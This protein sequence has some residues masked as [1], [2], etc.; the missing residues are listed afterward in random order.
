MCDRQVKKETLKSMLLFQFEVK[1][2]DKDPACFL[3]TCHNFY[4]TTDADFFLVQTD[5]CSVYCLFWLCLKIQRDEVLLL[6]FQ[7]RSGVF[8]QGVIIPQL[9]L[10]GALPLGLIQGLFSVLQDSRPLLLCA[11]HFLLK[12][13]FFVL[14]QVLTAQTLA[15]SPEL[16]ELG[17]SFRLGAHNGLWDITQR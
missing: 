5:L 9:D 4:V 14:L 16:L 17:V 8:S 13:L 7:P 15:S 12:L 6:V 2:L 10:Q 11:S 1:R 3:A